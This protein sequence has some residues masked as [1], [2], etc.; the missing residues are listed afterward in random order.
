MG[1]FALNAT[2]SAI[3][4]KNTDYSSNAQLRMVMR[5]YIAEKKET[6]VSISVALGGS[7]TPSGICFDIGDDQVTWLSGHLLRLH[8]PEEH[9]EAYQKWSL[10]YLPMDWPIS[11]TP[12][13][14]HREHLTQIIALARSADELVNAGEPDPEGQR[15]IDEVIEYAGLDKPVLRI[16]INDN[17][18]AAILRASLSMRSNKDFR[19]MSLSALARAVC[20]Q[21]YGFNLTRAYTL[22]ARKQGYVGVLSVGRVQTPILGLIVSRD[23][24][25]EEYQPRTYHTI[26]AS[27]DVQG[28][29]LLASYVP[30][31]GDPVDEDGHIN[32]LAFAQHCESETSRVVH[33]AAIISSINTQEHQIP[34]PLPHS[35]LSLQAEAA[36][37][38]SYAPRLVLEVTQRL[39]DEFKAITY[40]RSDC[41]FLNK[42]RY[43]EA[44][45]LLEKLKTIFPEQV[46][47]C[48]A[49]RRSDAF[50]SNKVT[51]HHGI[52]PTASVPDWSV[53]T[54]QEQNIYKL[55]STTYLAQFYP[56]KRVR[57]S[58]IIFDIG[59]SSFKAQGK[60]DVDLGWRAIMEGDEVTHA[61]DE[62][63]LTNLESISRFDRGKVTSVK[64][65]K[66]L[67]QAPTPYSMKTLLLDLTR[68][69][70]YVTDPSIKRLLLE[71]GENKQGESGGI[72]TAAT[73]HGHIETL[74]SRGFVEEQQG[75]LRSTPIGREFHNALPDFAVKP[76]LTA[77][78]HEKQLLI[79]SG[80]MDYQALI[81]EVD[82]II[83][84]EIKRVKKQGLELHV[85]TVTCPSCN[86]GHLT[87]RQ[88]ASKTPF[89]GCSSFPACKATFSD[90]K[91]QPQFIETLKVSNEHHCPQCESG[92]VRR[93]AKKEGVFWWGCSKYPSCTFRTFDRAGTPQLNTN[94]PSSEL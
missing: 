30:K 38:Y 31:F 9:N 29:Q 12:N 36:G 69:A 20:D 56:V 48:D 37:K 67:T 80:E 46:S 1:K 63:A 24:A 45:S 57:T 87:L 73:R 51:A 64:I 11:F 28:K 41:R 50:N 70:N 72:G 53:L 32:D 88:N 84:D 39:R 71:K 33:K 21:R 2:D 43:H 89:W 14:H 7:S 75:Y 85:K 25:Y 17:N 91:G 22:L 3:M 93:A 60:V 27:I 15:L 54:P 34:P 52:I 58:T 90:I 19:G 13:E 78:W 40:N 47:K 68:V 81:A 35:L 77:L 16:L 26:Q 8:K 10:D 79:E 92:L 61:S 74:F 86:K 65:N 62:I 5:L 6:A 18:P 59:E 82:A 44:P 55:I 94:P 23:K 42:E 83:A 66:Q 49:K 4:A 76:D